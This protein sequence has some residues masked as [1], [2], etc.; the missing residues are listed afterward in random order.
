LIGILRTE[1]KQSKIHRNV[2][3][4]AEVVIA[5]A[6]MTNREAHQ[7]ADVQKLLDAFQ[8]MKLALEQVLRTLTMMKISSRWMMSR[9][10]PLREKPQS[11]ARMAH[12]AA[13]TNAVVDDPQAELRLAPMTPNAWKLMKAKRNSSRSLRGSK[14]STAS[15]NPTWTIINE[16]TTAAIETA[17]VDLGTM[18][19]S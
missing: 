6:E 16:I 17:A 15:C 3:A 18:T 9:P 5:V 4:V 8:S 14:H 13:V 10:I 2:K 12:V 7:S 19:V 11:E 1:K